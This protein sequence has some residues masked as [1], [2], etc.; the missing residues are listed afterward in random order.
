MWI[1]AHCHLDAENLAAPLEEILE[2]AKAAKVENLVAVGVGRMGEALLEVAA[3]SEKHDCVYFTAGIHPHD[4][5]DLTENEMDLVRKM[6]SHP[7]CVALG[8][9]GLDYHY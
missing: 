5:K 1:D 6:L 2:R 8:E 4:V 9:V 3:L 7:R